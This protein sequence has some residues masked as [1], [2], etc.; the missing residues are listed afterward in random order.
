MKNHIEND[1]V[2]ANEE[3]TQ[4]K[5]TQK[6]QEEK[7][8]IVRA[9]E[10]KHA[11]ELSLGFIKIPK[12]K[13]FDLKNR[14]LN[15]PD[16]IGMFLFLLMNTNYSK[17]KY[18]KY[19]KEVVCERGECVYTIPEIGKLLGTSTPSARRFIDR[20]LEY[21]I[22]RAR[23][24]GYHARIISIVD[25]DTWVGAIVNSKEKEA[26]DKELHQSLDLFYKKYKTMTGEDNMKPAEGWKV[27]KSMTAE[28]RE[29][30]VNNIRNYYENRRKTEFA[31]HPV[32]YLKSKVYLSEFRLKF[33]SI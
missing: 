32:N 31:Y 25:Y 23:D 8:R 22:I 10:L 33:R 20:L 9:Q 30:A 5:T 7:E 19:G 13:L 12:K 21:N 24:I 18:I 28:E 2:A 6:Q 15:S 17:R 4:R 1:L 16:Q 14:V 11:D 27:W 26:L 3:T 29:L